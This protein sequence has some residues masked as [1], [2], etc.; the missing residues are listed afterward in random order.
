MLLELSLLRFVGRISY[1]LYLWQELA[2]VALPAVPIA[3]RLTGSLVAAVASYYLIEQPF[4]KF[5]VRL[6]Q[7]LAPR[8]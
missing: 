4:I 7:W 2:V 8:R 5:G 6:R 1:S 3:I